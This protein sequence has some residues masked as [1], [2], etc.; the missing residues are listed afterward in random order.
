VGKLQTIGT[1]REVISQ[2]PHSM[3]CYFNT[4]APQHKEAVEKIQGKETPLDRIIQATPKIRDRISRREARPA[5]EMDMSESE[6]EISSMEVFQGDDMVNRA[7]RKQQTLP[8]LR[9]NAEPTPKSVRR[10]STGHMQPLL[11]P[12]LVA[13]FKNNLCSLLDIYKCIRPIVYGNMGPQDLE[14]HLVDSGKRLKNMDSVLLKITVSHQAVQHFSAKLREFINYSNQF[15]RL[16]MR[17][18]KNGSFPPAQNLMDEFN[19]IFRSILP[20]AK[21][22]NE[23]SKALL[24]CN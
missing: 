24:V 15:W 6:S 13:F 3:E 9:T 20:I 7:L 19:K 8:H 12:T 23:G 22:I 11:P 16:C 2:N 17:I 18:Y 21:E 5:P 14:R 4:L 10:K 1:E